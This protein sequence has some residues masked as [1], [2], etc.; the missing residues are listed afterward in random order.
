[1]MSRRSRLSEGHFLQVT[2]DAMGF[3]ESEGFLGPEVFTYGLSY[4]DGTMVVQ[5]MYDWRD[6]RVLTLVRQATPMGTTASSLQCLYVEGGCGPAQDIRE[7][8]RSGRALEGVVATHAAALRRALPMV[9]GTDGHR[10][11][12][13]C[14]GR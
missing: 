10:L 5:L 9:R 14:H 2:C 3:L 6:G 13:L 1:M 8:A 4:S 7:I 11:M 12:C